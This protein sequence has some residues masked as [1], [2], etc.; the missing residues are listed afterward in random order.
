MDHLL[1]F[2]APLYMPM[3][4][5]VGLWIVSRLRKPNDFERAKLIAEIASAS[6]ALAASA[7]P[8]ATAAQLA[9]RVVADLLNATG[10]TKNRA[11]LE[12]AA[13]KAASEALSRQP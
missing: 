5:T 1:A 7:F 8:N 12:R 13:A 4:G 10:L 3:L 11:V 9:Q 6:A 2:L